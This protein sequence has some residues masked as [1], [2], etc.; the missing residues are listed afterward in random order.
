LIR[1]SARSEIQ[2]RTVNDLLHEKKCPGLTS[3]RARPKITRQSYQIMDRLKRRPASTKR[4]S[5]TYPLQ[6]MNPETNKISIMFFLK[7]NNI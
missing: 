5:F 2:W 4:G 3:A 1:A 6:P 7:V